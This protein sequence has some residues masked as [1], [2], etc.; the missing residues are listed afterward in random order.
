VANITGTLYSVNWGGLGISPEIWTFIMLAVATA[1]AGLMA[2]FRQDIAFML[3][4]VW[5]FFG[6]GVE[7]A[8][9]PQ[10]AAAANLAAGV[11]ALMVIIVIFQMVRKP[12]LAH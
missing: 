9:I 12:R 1:L 2:Y 7:Q 5:A 10:V 4:L 11:V 8:N 6:I 3:V